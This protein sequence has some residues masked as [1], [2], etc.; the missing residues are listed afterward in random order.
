MQKKRDVKTA[1][2]RMSAEERESLK[3]NLTE[4]N[5]AAAGDEQSTTANITLVYNIYKWLYIAFS[6]NSTPKRTIISVFIVTDHPRY[7]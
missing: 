3:W 7:E 1:Y 5:K 4:I 6:I 2:Q